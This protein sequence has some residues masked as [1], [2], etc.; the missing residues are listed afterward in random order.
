MNLCFVYHQSNQQ[1]MAVG[2]HGEPGDLVPLRAVEAHVRNDEIVI[3]L[4]LKT[5]GKAVTLMGL[6]MRNLKAVTVQ[7][8]LVKVSF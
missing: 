1:L 3:N 5:E 7:A 8:V 4:N 6:L 2:V